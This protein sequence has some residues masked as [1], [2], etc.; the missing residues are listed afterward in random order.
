MR[1]ICCYGIRVHS[2]KQL[3][4]ISDLAGFGLLSKFAFFYS[5][6]FSEVKR[7]PSSE[8]RVLY[9]Q[10]RNEYMVTSWETKVK[11]SSMYR[12][13]LCFDPIRSVAQSRVFYSLLLSICLPQC[14]L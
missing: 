7:F 5:P 3:L 6:I 4:L 1:C 2:K 13:V 9:G 8:F 14:H 10:L 12:K 11:L